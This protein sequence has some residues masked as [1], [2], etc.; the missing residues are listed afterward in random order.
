MNDLKSIALYYQNLGLNVN[1]I[2]NEITEH[3]FSKSET[4]KNPYHDY[5]HLLEEKQSVEEIL[6]FDWEKATGVGIVAGF[7]NLRVLDIDGCDNIDFISTLLTILRL[8]KDYE[9]VVKTGSNKGYHI[10]FYTN[11]SNEIDNSHFFYEEDNFYGKYGK[12][13]LPYKN[14]QESELFTATFFP[15]N[16]NLS[17]FEKM[18]FLWKSNVVAPF[19]LHKSSNHYKFHNTFLPLNKPLMVDFKRLKIIK[20]IFLKTYWH[21]YYHLPIIGTN[22]EYNP[23]SLKD[24]K[25]LSFLFDIETDG[26]INEN[27]YPQIVQISWAILDS[28][29]LILTRCTEYIKSDFNKNSEAFKINKLKPEFIEKYGK[30]EYFVLSKINSEIEKCN[31]IISHNISF[32]LEV[33][34]NRLTSCSIEF[35]FDRKR[36]ICTM[37]KGVEL[38]INDKNSNPKYPKLSELFF[39]IFGYR[40]IQSHDAYSDTSILIKCCRKIYTDE[41]L[42]K[43]FLFK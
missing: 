3:N 41:K 14:Y 7:E 16:D 20:N 22:I 28:E 8:P 34:K 2:K 36:K 40:V 38:F 5:L 26:L 27:N 1:C 37:K 42:K 11:E 18:D 32:D 13:G 15:N 24:F 9:W 6:S 29:G 43:I 12:V 19:S 30:D 25:N 23:F 33:L 10:Y 39:K 31:S 17:L 21:D 35:N 4:I